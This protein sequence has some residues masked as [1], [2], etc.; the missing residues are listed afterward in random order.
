[1]LA[2]GAFFIPCIEDVQRIGAIMVYKVFFI[3]FLV[4]FVVFG[5]ENPLDSVRE[6]VILTENDS[7]LIWIKQGR[8]SELESGQRLDWLEK[9]YSSL[10]SV[11]DDSLKTKYLSRL[12]LAYLKI[13]DSLLFRETNEKTMLLA[14]KTKDS[15]ALA[16]AHWDLAGF[17][18][19]KSFPDSAF[20]H[21]A[22][23]QEM[24]R[25]VDDK[26]HAGMMLYSMGIVQ[27]DVKDYMGSEISTIKAIELLKPLDAH[28]QLS[29]SYNNLAVV[30]ADLKDYNRAITYHQR[31]LEYLEKLDNVELSKLS[32]KNNIGAV[33]QKMEDFHSALPYFQE[34]LD[35]PKVI[36][37]NP[38]FY[39][40][41]LNN[42]GYCKLKLGELDQLPALFYE[43][44]QIQDS[45][46]DVQ[47]AAGT[48]H[49][50]AE[51]FLRQQDTVKALEHARESRNYALR[52][53]NNQRLLE[54][55][56]LL[57]RLDPKNALEYSQRY[58]TLN[59]S[60]LQEERQARNKF[61]RI[62]FETDEFIAQN[63]VLTREKQLWTGI[64]VGLFLLGLAAYLIIDQ[65]A[66]NQRLLFQQKQQAS[67]QEIFNLM[68]SQKK[69]REEGKKLEQKRISEELH[70]GV[71]SE[72]LGARMVLTG[73]NTRSDE[74]SISERNR[75]IDA[76]KQVEK[77]VRS[78]SHELS[79]A[80][81]QKINNFIRSIE[82]LLSPLKETA[83]IESSF[84][85]D[86]S[87]D[88]DG[89]TGDVKINLYR[90]IQ[91][92]LQN[93]VKHAECQNVYLS[94]TKEENTLLV[95]V[96][97]NGKGF[98]PK[99]GKKGIGMRN[100]ASRMEKLNGSWEV[101]SKIGKGS[102]VLFKIPMEKSPYSETGDTEE[103]VKKSKSA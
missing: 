62:R 11:P 70:D 28:R 90:I 87:V 3:Q 47:T 16:E 1:M 7:I 25:A 45:I 91:E 13:G 71:L 54:S 93:C 17:F 65:R 74:K 80:A 82:D 89:L 56:S 76:L 42:F 92:S 83:D 33:Y 35:N 95:S 18:R 84:T 94:F 69:E 27:A 12:S 53:L 10:K 51:Y 66:K 8:N 75:A 39:A 41:A 26:L 9:A 60:L 23:A 32:T 40:K 15:V 98:A 50:L 77:E 100:I 61:A 78:I 22:K 19:K 99:K 101:E 14:K 63:E 4:Y 86:D 88:W 72:M 59:D 43:A 73:L 44:L 34:V 58:I 67:N 31:A 57:P 64:A 79:H 52:S 103:I 5:N 21:F 97:D 49:N 96:K 36:K 102:T 46:G 30:T 55:L 6:S 24:Y 2:F 38:G 29:N 85:Y 37:N 68:L 20:F 48:Y 81:Y